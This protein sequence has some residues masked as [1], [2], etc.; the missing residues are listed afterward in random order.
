MSATFFVLSASHRVLLPTLPRTHPHN[1]LPSWQAVTWLQHVVVLTR[2]NCCGSWGWTEL[3]TTSK[4]C[5]GVEVSLCIGT[6]LAASGASNSHCIPAALVLVLAFIW[7]DKANPFSLSCLRVVALGGVLLAGWCLA[8]CRE[9]SVKEVLK[10]EYAQGINIIY[11]VRPAA[12]VRQLVTGCRARHSVV[13][14]SAERSA[15]AAGL[16]AHCAAQTVERTSLSHSLSFPLPGTACL[17]DCFSTALCCVCCTSP[18]SCASA[19]AHH[20][21]SCRAVCWRRHVQRVC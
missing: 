1:S 20:V 4:D 13:G 14:L 12:A 11:E 10:H 8:G 18:S 7:G 2:R 5:G 17:S 15:D 9:E 21:P 19:T 6:G 3:S 16:F